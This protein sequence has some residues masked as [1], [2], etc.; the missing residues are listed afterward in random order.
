[1]KVSEALR[2]GNFGVRL[3]L[4]V[5]FEVD[6]EDGT[7]VQLVDP[8]TAVQWFF[9]WFPRQVFDL[10]DQDRDELGRAIELYAR[11]MFDEVFEHNRQAGPA[12]E[13]RTDDPAWS[14]M[15]DVEHL[16]CDGA[17]ALRTVHR[18]AYQPTLEIVMAHL[19]VPLP[20]GLFE[21]RAVCADRMTGL[22]ETALTQKRLQSAPPGEDGL[23]ALMAEGRQ[24]Y[25]DDPAHD[26]TFPKHALSRARAAIRWLCNDS[27]LRV[28]QPAL[29]RAR[30]EI[31]LPALGCALT[32]PPR[33][34]LRPG[35]GPAEACFERCSF[36]GTDGN[37]TLLVR[38]EEKQ[39]GRLRASSLRERGTELVRS[40]HEQAKVENVHLHVEELG[41]I[42]GQPHVLVIAEGQGH[43]GPL[44]NAFWWF[45][46]EAGR[47]WYLNLNATAAVPRETRAAELKAAAQ[48]WRLTA[49][50]PAKKPWWKPW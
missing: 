50:A 21:A 33:F 23:G 32:P 10:G 39:L 41:E 38:C 15:V 19:L 4:P 35:D 47:P 36:C 14:P 8:E 31:A 48:S 3:D 7:S 30:G 17:P 26:S 12:T 16:A 49:A 11:R 40:I 42:A 28:L 1:M 24:Q 5:R 44:R 20:G 29:P 37:E 34:V 22:R 43:Q 6:L 9:F 25:F 2:A 46:D 45:L 27:G 18:M 13:P